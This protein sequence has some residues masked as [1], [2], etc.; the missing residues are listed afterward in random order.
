MNLRFLSQE[1]NFERIRIQLFDESPV[2]HDEL[3]EIN[4]TKSGQINIEPQPDRMKSGIITHLQLIE[5]K[6]A[7]LQSSTDKIPSEP[8]KS[9]NN[10]NK[11]SKLI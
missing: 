2:I 3:K 10:Y 8:E 11:T 7:N 1:A 6:V 9:F 4:E 5:N